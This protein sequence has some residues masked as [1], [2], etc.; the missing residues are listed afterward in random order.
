MSDETTPPVADEPED[1]GTT[2]P[3]RKGGLLV[4]LGWVQEIVVV[5]VIALVISSLIR[6]F[7]GQ[8]FVIPSGS[9]ENTLL[10]NDRVVVSK[11]T[12]VHRGDVVV[13]KDPGG[14]LAPAAQP[15]GWRKAAEFLGVLPDTSDQ[16]LIKR[17]I[18][19]P[20]DT[21][22]WSPEQKQLSVNGTLLDEST[23]L[24]SDASGLVAPA[25]VAF[26]VVVPKDTVFVM[27]DHR[28]DSYDS[29][30]HLADITNDGRP[31]GASAFVPMAD[32]VGPAVQIVAPLDRWRTMKRPA[33]FDTVASGGAAPEQATIVP[34]GVGCQ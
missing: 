28:N 31:R 33:V 29:R 12:S 1:S 6:A 24:Y 18:G 15:T 13:F 17:I 3:P 11:V 16:H 9:M 26:E 34:E 8:V 32:V 22:K 23:Y 5:A 30:C 10:I 7:L 27:G 2:K 4:L 14:W 19:M 25:S 21:V 20:G